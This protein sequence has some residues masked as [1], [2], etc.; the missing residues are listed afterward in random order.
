MD[1]YP[2]IREWE[3]VHELAIDIQWRKSYLSV[4]KYREKLSATRRADLVK[5]QIQT[6]KMIS[7]LKMMVMK[8]QHV[9]QNVLEIY[10]WST[11][12]VKNKKVEM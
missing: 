4:F 11:K 10:Y 5:F 7:E 12:I 3:S 1:Y 2:N 6:S 8:F 9:P